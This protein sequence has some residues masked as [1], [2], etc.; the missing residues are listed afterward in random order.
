[1]TT[2]PDLTTLEEIVDED[3]HLQASRLCAAIELWRRTRAPRWWRA[4][5][6]LRATTP[7]LEWVSPSSAWSPYP[8]QVVAAHPDGE[9]VAVAYYGGIGVQHPTSGRRE[10]YDADGGGLPPQNSDQALT[11]ALAVLSTGELVYSGFS[12]LVM[13][14]RSSGESRT[15]CELDESLSQ[16]EIEAGEE[17]VLARTTCSRLV[18]FS[19]K[20]GE[21]LPVPQELAAV[22]GL[23]PL[24]GVAAVFDQDRWSFRSTKDGRLLASASADGDGPHALELEVPVENILTLWGNRRSEVLPVPEGAPPRSRVDESVLAATEIGSGVSIKLQYQELFLDLQAATVVQVT[25][26][27]CSHRI[28]VPRT[29]LVAHAYEGASLNFWDVDTGRQPCLFPG[30]SEE[31][32]EVQFNDDGTRLVS[33]SDDQSAIEWDTAT[34]AMIRRR[35]V[36]LYPAALSVEGAEELRVWVRG[37][38]LGWGVEGSADDESK[39]CTDPVHPAFY[40][41]EHTR[42]LCS[43]WTELRWID[44]QTKEAIRVEPFEQGVSRFVASSDLQTIAV[45]TEESSIELL[46][47]SDRRPLADTPEAPF[48]IALSR[49]ASL[50]A[51]S[52][53]SADADD[54]RIYEL[55]SGRCLR[56]LQGFLG[57]VSA[58]DHTGD[59][60]VMSGPYWC[61]IGLVEWRTG[62]ARPHWHGGH[63]GINERVAFSRDGRYMATGAEDSQVRLSRLPYPSD[64]EGLSAV[65]A[66]IEQAASNESVP[67]EIEKILRRW[68]EET[69][70]EV[71]EHQG[72]LFVFDTPRPGTA[73][74]DSP[75]A[76]S[77]L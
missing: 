45:I 22:H 53:R 76:S 50:L 71:G 2:E 20:T 51:V 68:S 30:H 38:N 4:V 52:E 49:D 74:R 70:H 34:G 6:E 31:I 75:F 16:L 61:G 19:L 58:F 41:S 15:L 32:N 1:M 73:Y 62:I 65:E 48:G 56:K 14:D 55:P 37:A 17:S 3:S 27:F 9:F 67:P 21:S 60:I 12:R 26:L 59:L 77:C 24:G 36:G 18:R 72:K 29:R 44:L 46:I 10:W 33:V 11:M 64:D 35:H 42:V 25:A 54:L 5:V 7:R 66:W 8:P 57:S 23:S 47:G 43:S 69:G 40:N 39:F 13:V 63:S 28:E